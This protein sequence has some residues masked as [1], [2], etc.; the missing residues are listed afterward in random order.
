MTK[1][2][3]DIEYQ[4]MRHEVAEENDWDFEDDEDSI[5]RE[6]DERFFEK[7]GIEYIDII[8]PN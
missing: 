4:K 8:L 7:F 6:A 2:Q 3:A 5:N 1:Q